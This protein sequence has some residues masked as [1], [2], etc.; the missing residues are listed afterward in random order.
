MLRSLACAFRFFA[1]SV[2]LIASGA[3]AQQGA[4]V[5]APGVPL[6]THSAETGLPYFPPGSGTI[7]HEAIT[8]RVLEVFEG[9]FGAFRD[10]SANLHDVAV[11]HCAGTADEAALKAAF[12]DTW[13]AWAPLDSY[14]FGPIEQQGAALTVNFWPDKKNFVG[15]A[16]LDLTKQ[17][18][19]A[20]ADGAVVATL[21]AGA[22][23]L[24]ALEMLIYDDSIPA[25]P[26]VQGV[27]ANLARLAENIYQGWFSDNGWADLARAA[28]PDNP[29]Y[30]APSEF[31]K[32]V[33]TALDFGLIRVADVRL[34]RPLGTFERPFPTRAE[35]WRSGLTAQ[36]ILAQ[37][38]GIEEV[39]MSGF[40]GDLGDN[41]RSWM[42]TLFDQTEDRAAAIDAPIYEAVA[43]PMQRIRV[44][45]LQSKVLYLQNQMA[46]DVGPNLGVETGFSAADGD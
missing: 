6:E 8:R 25:C 3:A 30:L 39:V 34:G 13:M 35:A 41:T 46:Q 24:P 44:E 45:G 20:Q 10:Q 9:Q 33:Y 31:T 21:S 11:A 18:P 40:A 22:Q 43:D 28:G 5:D 42:R 36:I 37:L 38:E 2:A 32:V 7:S 17:S 23:G 29:V 16:L 15:R 26:A 19:E 27:S 4:N 12:V 14:Q 1:L